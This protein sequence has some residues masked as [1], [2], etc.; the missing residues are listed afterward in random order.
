MPTSDQLLAGR[1]LAWRALAVLVMAAAVLYGVALDQGV[2]LASV[3]DL[4]AAD[5][6]VLHDFF[7]DARH[8]LGVPCH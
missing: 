2:L 4:A 3:S 5:G 1:D 8:L 7:H 6:S